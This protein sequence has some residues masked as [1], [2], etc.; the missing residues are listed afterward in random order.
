MLPA[1]QGAA[2]HPEHNDFVV[3]GEE[4]PGNFF[5]V[6]GKIGAHLYVSLSSDLCVHYSAARENVL[7]KA[8]VMEAVELPPSLSSPA[9]DTSGMQITSGAV[10]IALATTG[11]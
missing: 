6:N 10:N 2:A 1:E 5:I 4:T 7:K 8:F 9:R 11:T 3:R